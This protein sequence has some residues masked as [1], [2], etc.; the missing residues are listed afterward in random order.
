M[1]IQAYVGRRYVLPSPSVLV[2]DLYEWVLIT[3]YRSAIKQIPCYFLMNDS[4]P[5][6]QF[7]IKSLGASI[8]ESIHLGHGRSIDIVHEQF[9]VSTQSCISRLSKKLYSQRAHLIRIQKHP[10]EK[11]EERCHRN[12]VHAVLKVLTLYQ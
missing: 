5:T 3:Q 1:P 9:K 10:R 2:H 7:R 4:I 6:F 8:K 12:E 11:F